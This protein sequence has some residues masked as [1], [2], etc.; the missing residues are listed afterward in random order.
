MLSAL[1]CNRI[2]LPQP[3]AQM[4]LRGGYGKGRSKGK[5]LFLFRLPLDKFAGGTQL[6]SGSKQ[7]VPPAAPATASVDPLSL[8]DAAVEVDRRHDMPVVRKRQ[9]GSM[10]AAKS[11]AQDQQSRSK[12][13]KAMERD[14][15]ART[16]VGPRE[17]QLA[18]WIRLHKCWFGEAVSPWPLTE[19]KLVRVSAL[20]KAGHYRSYKNYVSRAK[21]FHLSAGYEWTDLL[22]RT[23]QK[24]T[25]SVLRGLAGPS[26]SEAF[27]F[28]AVASALT[29]NTGQLAQGGPKN[30]L[31]MIVCATYFMLREIEASGIQV[32]DI[33]FGN[34]EVT[35][36]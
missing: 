34:E 17:A 27:D 10:S 19:G 31:A 33:S 11:A 24:C 9:L 28:A 21:D 15:Y 5:S 29:S 3:F 6:V 25:R 35:L 30:P 14:M 2:H 4:Y 23:V 12:A 1:S 13:L 20:F 7:S 8:D 26:R 32:G 16:S 22:Q 36:P 18:T